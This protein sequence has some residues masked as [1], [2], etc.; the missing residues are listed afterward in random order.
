MSRSSVYRRIL[1]GALAVGFLATGTIA[2]SVTAAEAAGRPKPPAI[3]PLLENKDAGEYYSASQLESF[4]RDQL[5]TLKKKHENTFLHKHLN[6]TLLGDSYTAGN[7]AGWYYQ[8]KAYR[9]GLNWGHE[10]A[11]IIKEQRD[12]DT[13]ITNLAHS[14]D[15][16]QDVL[17]YQVQNI[18]TDT[19]L[20]MM[21]IGG[22]DV[23]FKH[24]VMRCFV[25]AL[26]NAAACAN[27]IGEA[28]RKIPE[29]RERT[30][31]I[32]DK[33][34]ERLKDRPKGLPKAQ[35]TLVS[36]PH[37]AMNTPLLPGQFR[38][39]GQGASAWAHCSV[40]SEASC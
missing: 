27:L 33:L 30:A 28:E 22:N 20:V 40:G 29:V 37:L 3:V 18:L 9:S 24:I 35:L 8:S 38:C 16:T 39:G 12:I 25:P 19:D 32:F 5:Y 31:Q 6:L 17:D 13:V 14:D 11:R 21:T 2:V 15:V 34:A 36:Y 7:G 23:D 26:Q 10:F 4:S 1:A